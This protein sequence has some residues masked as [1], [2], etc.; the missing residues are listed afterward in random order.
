MKL[1]NAPSIG[2][3]H[4][5]PHKLIPKTLITQLRTRSYLH[6]YDAQGRGRLRARLCPRPGHADHLTGRGVN[7]P[8]S[9]PAL[10]MPLTFKIARLTIQH[11]KPCVC[12]FLEATRGANHA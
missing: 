7:D 10:V 4:I 3:E 8:G 9:A 1:F 2:N 5:P 12:L 11:I 6:E